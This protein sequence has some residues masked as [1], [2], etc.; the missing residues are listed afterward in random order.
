[1]CWGSDTIDVRKLYCSSD[2]IVSDY[3]FSC[4]LYVIWGLIWT[5]FV[6]SEGIGDSL[7]SVL[8]WV[9][10][11]YK[12]DLMVTFSVDCDVRNPLGRSELQGRFDG[13]IFRWLWCSKSNFYARSQK[14]EKRLLASS[15][16]PVRLSDRPHGM[17]RLPLDG[18]VW[19]LIFE[20]FLKICRENSSFIKIWQESRVLYAKTNV[21]FW[22]CLAQF[23]LL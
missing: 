19:N 20:C 23:L 12:A 8:F 22:S 6:F 4:I 9:V 3:I 17:P 15:C 10:V 21:H 13:N 1:M 11:N 16:L 5:A 14:C 7:K 18:F 2:R